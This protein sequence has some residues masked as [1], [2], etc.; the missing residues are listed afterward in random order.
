[1]KTPQV[2]DDLNLFDKILENTSKESKLFV[3]RSLAIANQ[4]LVL[5]D[6]KGLKQKDLANMLNKKEAE[7][8]R[9]LT[10]FHNFTVKSIAKIEAAL[11]EQI[12]YTAQESQEEVSK[13]VHALTIKT[14]VFER[15]NNPMQTKDFVSAGSMRATTSL[16][17]LQRKTNK[18]KFSEEVIYIETAS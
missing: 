4:I 17:V 8:S 9:W 13:A 16:Y 6:K 14:P 11:G 7:I 3:S 12:I 5:L 15:A 2:I 10:G 18:E 1:M